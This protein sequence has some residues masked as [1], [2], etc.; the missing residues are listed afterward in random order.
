MKWCVGEEPEC[1]GP[2]CGEANTCP[3]Y[4]ESVD[5]G[6]TDADG[7]EKRAKD[8][9][10]SEKPEE[11]VFNCRYCGH[12][13]VLTWSGSF[14]P[15][16]RPHEGWDAMRYHCPHCRAEGPR[17]DNDLSVITAVDEATRFKL[18]KDWL[19]TIM[20]RPASNQKGRTE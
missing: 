8:V 5:E 9:S 11:R 4:L 15:E 18:Q 19:D 20:R 17:V 2:D 16:Y 10:T 12:R 7:L 14:H 3:Y 13:M 1:N 6:L